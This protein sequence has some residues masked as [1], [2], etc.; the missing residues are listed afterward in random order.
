[1]FCNVFRANRDYSSM[2]Y[3]LLGFRTEMEC[4]YWAIW[5]EPLNVIQADGSLYIISPAFRTYLHLRV[6]LTG[7]NGRNLRPFQ[8]TTVFQKF[9]SIGQKITLKIQLLLLK[10][11]NLKTISIK[12]CHKFLFRVAYLFLQL[13]SKKLKSFEVVSELYT[14]H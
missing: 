6:A 4:V 5:T 7:T 13:P 9:G 11:H 10:R 8:T 1:V 3:P 12:P 14:F 2:Q